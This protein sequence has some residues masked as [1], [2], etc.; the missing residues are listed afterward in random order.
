MISC[1]RRARYMAR[2][3]SRVVGLFSQQLQQWRELRSKFKAFDLDNTC[4]TGRVALL[5]VNG[6]QVQSSLSSPRRAKDSSS[7]CPWHR[8]RA[9][10]AAL[11]VVCLCYDVASAFAITWSRTFSGF[12]RLATTSPVPDPDAWAYRHNAPTP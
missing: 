7:R 11:L 12:I 5:Y 6:P 3:T 10:T 4:A 8:S 1:A 9:L 2:E